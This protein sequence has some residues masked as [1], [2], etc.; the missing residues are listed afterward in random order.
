MQIWKFPINIIDEQEVE[1]PHGAEI[2]SAQM[3]GEEL[4]LWALV[5][6]ACNK[7][8]R[9]IEIFGTGNPITP[10]TRKFI[11]TAQMFGG[12]LVWH[13]FERLK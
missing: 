7:T 4:C 3:Q 2:L 6:P 12:R 1:M 11:G 5:S 9:T 13:V 10:A 8:S